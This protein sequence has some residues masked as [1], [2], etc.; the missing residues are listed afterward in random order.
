MHYFKEALVS[1]WRESIELLKPSSFGLLLLISLRTLLHTYRALTAAW[2][3]PIAYSIGFFAFMF[4]LHSFFIFRHV[5]LGADL[6][7][8]YG[9]FL[10]FMELITGASLLV[11]YMSLMVRAA[12]PSIDYKNAH[13]WLKREIAHW[14]LFTATLLLIP[15][16]WFAL[17]MVGSW[18][19]VGLTFFFAKALLLR[20]HDWL[21]GA[22]VLGIVTTFLSPFVILWTLFMYDAQKTVWQYIRSFWRALL[23]L[24]YNYPFFFIIYELLRLL[25]AG[26]YLLSRPFVES[27]P[28]MYI[29]GWIVLF[30]LVIPYYVCLLTN[31]YVKRLHEQFSVYY[32]A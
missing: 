24:F 18:M 9:P 8:A 17:S 4:A 27:Y 2:F 11:F 7:F 15:V 25:L 23:M 21:P 22:H 26:F 31:V 28:S 19:R 12:R 10:A 16:A 30:F 20:L 6:P 13:Y 29:I 32:R 1:S 14:V 5:P 3:L